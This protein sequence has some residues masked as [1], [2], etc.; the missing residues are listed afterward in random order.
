MMHPE[1]RYQLSRDISIL[2]NRVLLVCMLNPSTADE[3][4]NDPTISRLCRLAEN[5]GFG[6]LLVLNLLAIRATNPID[7]WLHRDPLGADNW[8]TWDKVLEALV[9]GRDSISV[10]W[11][12]AP[13]SRSQF[14]QFVPIL[15]EASHRLKDWSAPLMTWVQNV[16]GSPRHP[17]YISVC[18]ELKPYNLDSYVERLSK[19]QL[20]TS[21][22]NRTKL[23]DQEGVFK[24]RTGVKKLPRHKL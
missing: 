7:I 5:A 14:S 4:K 12:R 8:K 24:D 19:A 18:A 11:G 20:T 16:D 15:V 23:L 22:R 9:P 2:S 3:K 1:Y 13:T 17:L 21:T 10:A 6:R